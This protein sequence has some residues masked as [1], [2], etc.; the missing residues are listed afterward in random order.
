MD[1]EYY[2]HPF[3]FISDCGKVLKLAF[4]RVF[5]R[6]LAVSCAKH[7]QAN[8]KAKFGQ[9]CA[10]YVIQLAKAFLPEYPMTCLMMSETSSQK[11]QTTLKVWKMFGV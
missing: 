1:G 5:P 11:W 3:V 8:V 2:H 10:R 7:I 6:N 9:L 4:C